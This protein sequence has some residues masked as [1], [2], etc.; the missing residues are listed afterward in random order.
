MNF[1]QALKE[2]ISTGRKF[3]RVDYGTDYEDRSYWK[4]GAIDSFD[5]D[6]ADLLA[7]YEMEPEEEVRAEVEVFTYKV[8]KEDIDKLVKSVVKEIKDEIK[9][10]Y[11]KE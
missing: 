7:E 3:R 4:I 1:I 6:E 5:L 8:R 9:E 11:E 10:L 2:N